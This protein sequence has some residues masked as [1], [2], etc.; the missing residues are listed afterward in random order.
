MGEL[1]KYDIGYYLLSAI[2]KSRQKIECFKKN[3]FLEEEINV[4]LAGLLSSLT[5][6]DQE[7][8]KKTISLNEIDI[9][10]LVSQTQEDA[11]KY[12]IYKT[13]AD[14]LLVCLGLFN[15]IGT[16]FKDR[17]QNYYLLA[18]NYHHRVYHYRTVLSQILEKLSCDLDNYLQLL[19]FLRQDYFRIARTISDKELNMIIE[20]AK[21][22]QRE[23]LLH[24]KWDIF[25]D[26]YSLWLKTKLP[27]ALERLNFASEELKAID[28][29]FKFKV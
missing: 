24:K 28:P 13:N 17:L 3:S 5:K 18:S 9:V 6:V 15:N 21:E 26:A 1:K 12:F 10:S 20:Q 22:S 4:Y 8:A 23:I 16:N 27:E 29:T 19:Y 2:L 25:L 11:Q 7:F 14:Y